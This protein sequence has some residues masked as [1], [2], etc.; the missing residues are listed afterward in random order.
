MIGIVVV[1]HGELAKSLVNTA[2]LIVGEQKCIIDVTI[3]A[4]DGPEQIKKK[5]EYAI[6]QTNTDDGVLIFTDMLGG[7]PSISSLSF[8]DKYKIE[9]VAGVNLPMILEAILHREKFNLSRLA[10][11]VVEKTKK[12]IVIATL[13]THKKK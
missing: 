13:K 7:S 8:T 5:I 10:K 4:S 9:I 2:Y 3:D 11:I 1:S 6:K 12:S